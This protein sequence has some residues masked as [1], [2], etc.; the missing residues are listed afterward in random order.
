MCQKNTCIG[1]LIQL[2]A[3]SVGIEEIEYVSSAIKDAC[4]TYG[5]YIKDFEEKLSGVVGKEVAVCSSG[6]AALHLILDVLGVG[7]GDE[8]IVPDISFISTVN[9]V[10]YVG[11]TP[12]LCDVG[13][14][15]YIFSINPNLI[16]SLITPK[17]K[18]II[19]AHLF[20][21]CGNIEK[22]VKIAKKNGIFLIEDA[23]QSLGSTYGGKALGTFGDAGMWSFNGN[24]IITSAGGGAVT[25][26]VR[27]NIMLNRIRKGLNQNKS[28]IP[29]EFV[30][31]GFNYRLSNIHAAIGVAQLGKLDRFIKKKRDLYS[32]YNNELDIVRQMRLSNCWLSAY[33][34]NGSASKLSKKLAVSG[35]ECRPLYKPFH[36]IEHTSLFSRCELEVSKKL[37]DRI[38]CL[39]SGVD[40]TKDQ[41]KIVIK[42]I[43]EID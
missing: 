23:A 30:G 5:S 37:N 4:L 15:D 18:A 19:V 11:A 10:L 12:V 21:S 13:D 27:G 7:P 17:T 8:V 32:F 25:C 34:T 22:L 41:A 31:V 16:E 33:R 2:H 26:S 1:K 9:A 14:P 36:L 6:T 35:I 29:G 3:P 42:A 20:G 39:P 24:K 28:I 40:I 38:L 43:Q